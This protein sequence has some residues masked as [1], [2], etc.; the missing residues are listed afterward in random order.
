MN[1]KKKSK[2]LFY[3]ILFLVPFFILSI[4]CNRI[5]YNIQIPIKP[6]IPP[7]TEILILGDSHAAFALDPEVIGKTVNFSSYGESYVHNYY[8]LKFALKKSKSL[9]IV[10][11]PIDLHSFSDFRE[12]RIHFN[13]KW[14]QYIDFI[15]LGWI[16]NK[17]ISYLIKYLHLRIF[18]FKGHYLQFINHFFSHQDSQKS[19][20]LIDKGFIA[21]DGFYFHKQDEKAQRRASRQLK[22]FNY[23]SKEIVLF[24]KKILQECEDNQIQVVLMKSP[25]TRE[26]YKQADRLI[27]IKHLYSQVFQI[28]RKFRNIHLLDFQTLYFKNE[29][30]LFWDPQHLNKIG[31]SKFSALVKNHLVQHKLIR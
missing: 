27:N 20:L 7:N 23:F 24:F 10:I 2:A 12:D 15:E 1:R 19:N 25:I 9:K 22:D 13:M 18:E 31:A 21:K 14:L 11:L 17:P 3:L 6:Y 30:G 28:A 8:K 5:Y 4:I 26:Y 16:K 29:S